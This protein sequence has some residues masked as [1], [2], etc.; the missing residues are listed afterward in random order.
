MDETKAIELCLKHKDPTGFEQL[1]RMF[2]REAYMH[3]F[4]MLGNQDDAADACQDAFAKAFSAMPRVQS[5]N[6]FYPWFYS[7]LRNYCLNLIARRKTAENFRKQEE[8]HAHVEAASPAT[9]AIESEEQHLVW[10]ALWRLQPAHR[11][12]LVLKYIN[13]KRYDEIAELLNIPRGTVMSRLFHARIAF[14]D[15][16]ERKSK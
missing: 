9:I 4:G 12:I 1:V 5:L 7:I 2:R 16:W 10:E 3:A 14:R 11:E 15:A 6:R 13:G 8:E